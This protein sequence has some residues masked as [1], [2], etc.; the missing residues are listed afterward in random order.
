MQRRREIIS[1]TKTQPI[2]LVFDKWPG[3]NTTS[4]LA[5]RNL[6]LQVKENDYSVTVYDYTG[7]PSDMKLPQ[8]NNILLG[9]A[10]GLVALRGPPQGDV[11]NTLGV[12]PAKLECA[13]GTNEAAEDADLPKKSTLASKKTTAVSKKPALGRESKSEA[14]T[15]SSSED[16][17]PS[18]CGLGASGADLAPS[19]R[20]IPTRSKT[21]PKSKSNTKSNEDQ[22]ENDGPDNED[23]DNHGGDVHNDD[24]ND[25]IFED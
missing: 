6:V 2:D 20:T 13:D 5:K 24:N 25:S 23:V 15:L 21:A 10:K 9:F 22:D 4:T 17:G 14:P 18:E 8:M 12:D 11:A 7:Q 16:E 3:T 1:R 19:A